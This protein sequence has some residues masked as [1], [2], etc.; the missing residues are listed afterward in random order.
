MI[1]DIFR[2]LRGSDAG[3]V[4]LSKISL[5]LS[6]RDKVN[7][8]SEALSDELVEKFNDVDFDVDTELEEYDIPPE[9][10]TAIKK[11]RT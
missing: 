9:T 6:L 1:T 11:L 4:R 2:I 7:F 5:F 3:K 8:F 10:S